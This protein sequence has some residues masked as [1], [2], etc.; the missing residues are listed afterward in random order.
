MRELKRDSVHLVV[1]SPPYWQIK[2]YGHGEQIGFPESLPDYLRRLGRVW[3]E[4]ERVLHPGCRLV[5]NIGDQYHRAQGGRPYHITPLNAHVVN[6]VLESTRGRMVFLGNIIWQKISNTSTSGGASVMGSYGSPRN[7]YV[8]LDYEYVSIFKKLGKDPPVGREVKEAERIELPEWRQLFAGHWKFP[9]ATQSDHP[10][11]F[12]EELPRR[13]IR[14]FTFPKDTVL[15]PFLG[16]GTTIRAADRMGRNGIGYEIGWAPR[17]G[18]DWREVVRRV[19]GYYDHPENARK[20]RFAFT[21]RA[22]RQAST[23]RERIAPPGG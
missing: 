12:P 18:S 3:R 20:D 22:K 6:G 5:V 21:Q 8:S 17:D 7:G 9:G 15:D 2:D 19:V 23:R 14:M 1:T 11:P 16:S 4:C 10:A 13:L